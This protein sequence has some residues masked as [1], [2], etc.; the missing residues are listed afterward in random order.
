MAFSGPNKSAMADINVTPLIDV[1]LVLLI[2]FMVTTAAAEQQR[3]EQLKEQSV[4]ELVEETES[5]AAIH[6]PVTEDNGLLADPKTTKLVMVVDPR[7]RVFIVKGLQAPVEG[8][9]EPQRWISD[10]SAHV[11]ATDPAVWQPCFDVVAQTLN[12]NVRL[13]REGLYLEG[14]SDVPYGFVSGLMAT[15]RDIGVEKIHIVTNPGFFEDLK[16]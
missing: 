16:P 5:L 11:D 12:G 4:Q 2:I 14:D 7:L 10:C 8:A 13:L 6:L 15:L 3:T 9:A 1:L